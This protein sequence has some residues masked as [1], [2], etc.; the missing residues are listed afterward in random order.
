[1]LRINPNQILEKSIK[2]SKET[3]KQKSYLELRKLFK[4]R[5]HP[6]DFTDYNREFGSHILDKTPIELANQVE[7]EY[8]FRVGIQGDCWTTWDR[9]QLSVIAL[10]IGEIYRPNS[11]C[12]NLYPEH[13]E[14][15]KCN[16][17]NR[18]KD[19]WK[20][21]INTNIFLEGEYLHIRPDNLYDGIRRYLR[22]RPRLHTYDIQ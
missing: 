8:W 21:I 19:W 15:H 2:I 11:S 13:I 5:K 14:I 18:L 12:E 20:F 4:E 9:L 7:D 3:T 22:P 16:N 17:T 10:I 1:M 6:F